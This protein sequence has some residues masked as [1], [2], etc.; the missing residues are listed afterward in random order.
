MD[1]KK[2]LDEKTL[3][4]VTGGSDLDEV[5]RVNYFMAHNCWRC[6]RTMRCHYGNSYNAYLALGW[7]GECKEME[8]KQQ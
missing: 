4:E 7:K 2:I 8:P 3:E 6:G 1:K 5:G